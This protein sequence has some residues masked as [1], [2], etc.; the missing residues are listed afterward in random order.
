MTTAPVPRPRR[1]PEISTPPPPVAAVAIDTGPLLCFGG[2]L[3]GPRLLINRYK[4]RL[5]WAQAV[6]EEIRNRASRNVR[7]KVQEKQQTAASRWVG[8]TASHLGEPQVI[9][10]RNAVEVMRSAVQNAS[11]WPTK[12]GRDLGESETLVLAQNRSAMALINERPARAVARRIGLRTHC[13]LDVIVAAYQEGSLELR[14]VQRMYEQMR[15]AELDSGDTLPSP[16]KGR[17][18]KHWPTPAPA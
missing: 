9:Q 14:E 8:A 6:E 4:G 1:D 7:T 18:L 13:A 12:E 3:G 2:I 15:G 16:C 17:S 5:C 11:K 10:D